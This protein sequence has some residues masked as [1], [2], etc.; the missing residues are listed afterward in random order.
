ML[1]TPHCLMLGRAV[2]RHPLLC[3]MH[4][5]CGPGH[6]DCNQHIYYTSG[7]RLQTPFKWYVTQSLCSP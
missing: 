6:P 2:L 7:R 3:H 1:S 5:Y 4:M